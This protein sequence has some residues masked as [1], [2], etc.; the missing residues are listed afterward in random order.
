MWIFIDS[1]A[2]VTGIYLILRLFSKSLSSQF[3]AKE[4]NRLI[5]I[6]LTAIV[7]K[8][9]ITGI[10]FLHVRH[11]FFIHEGKLKDSG[12]YDIAGQHLA[13]YFK[14]GVFFRPEWLDIYGEYIGFPYYLG[15]VYTLFGHSQIMVS[16]LNA[17]A[18]VITALLVF[19]IA[20]AV[21]NDKRIAVMALIFNLFYAQYISQS[22]YILKDT[23]LLLLVMIFWHQVINI[24]RD[25][26]RWF[27]YLGLVA[28]ACWIYFMRSPL[29]VIVVLLG[30]THLIVRLG[31][32]ERRI[33]KAGLLL[34]VSMAGVIYL[35]TFAPRSRTVFE[36]IEEIPIGQAG[37]RGEGTPAYLEGTVGVKEI[38][39]RIIANPFLAATD[40]LRS[41]FLIYWGPPYFYQ[42]TGPRLFYA[43]DKFIF[44]DNLGAIMRIL[45]M[46][47]VIYGFLYCLRYKKQESFLLY[48]FLA[49]WTLAMIVTGSDERWN[50]E[51]MPFT[52]VFG[53]VG[54]VNFEKVKPFYLIYLLIFNLFIMAN[55]TL[56][57]GLIVAK[58]LLV[59][60]AGGILWGLT[61]YRMVPGT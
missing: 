1:V 32:K 57:D 20:L 3:E 13:S 8:L 52:L 40:T 51:L 27:N 2:L 50:I 49:V 61:K 56:H 15:L 45:L 9:A 25:R 30:G 12:L 46:P 37:Y 4:V 31:F 26:D 19:Q 55:A 11:A 6:V 21:F 48:G 16:C 18:S 38:A 17:L 23:F 47:M 43:Y 59:L 33:V 5:L 58:P 53:A 22:Y 42:R 10:W 44:Y 41:I 34:L 24:G 60:T 39:T 35:G 29:A 28:L 7:L 54:A 36:K 14:R